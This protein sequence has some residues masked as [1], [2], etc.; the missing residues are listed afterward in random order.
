[1]IYTHIFNKI[2]LV[3]SHFVLDYD[4]MLGAWHARSQGKKCV[5]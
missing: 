5:K 2:F 3:L 4:L 1:M